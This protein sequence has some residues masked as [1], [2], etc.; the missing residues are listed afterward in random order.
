MTGRLTYTLNPVKPS[1]W[2][3]LRLAISFTGKDSLIFQD[4]RRFGK[5]VIV[6]QGKENDFFSK[7][8][9]EP[10]E[11]SFGAVQLKQLLKNRKRPIKSFL[12][13]Q[14]I[15]AGIG[16]IYAD[17]ALYRAGI[18]PLKE[19][20][21]LTGEEAKRLSH[22]IKATLRL[23]IALQGSSIDTYRDSQGKPGS[24]QNVFS[25]HRREGKPCHRCKKSIKKIKVGGRGTYYCPQC[26]P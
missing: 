19:A 5:A 21:S 1:A 22:A 24:F 20:C 11:R 6:P 7:L 10:L 17:E 23:A 25:V 2:R 3:H 16:N 18:H 15:I 14:S 8:G 4:Q 9:P 13:D 26:Q 12:L